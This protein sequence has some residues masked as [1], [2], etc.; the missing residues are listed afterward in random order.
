MNEEINA[1]ECELIGAIIGDGHI[2]K[3]GPKYYVG[4]TG[5]I[6]TDKK[7]FGYLSNLI[8]KT[9]NKSPQIRKRAGGLRLRF[10]S[11]EVV[12]RLIKKFSLPFNLGKCYKVKIPDVIASD[13]GLLRH[14]IRGIADTDGSVFTANKPGSPNYPSIEITTT[15][16]F[17]ASQLRNIL[18]K[19]GFKVA[20]IW[21]YKSKVSRYP[22]YKI[23]LNGRKNL[24]KWLKEIGFSNP[25][26]LNKA[27]NAL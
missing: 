19:Q 17:L 5:N 12:E 6:Q 25:Y 11:K 22:A 16:R 26:K 20:K 7:Y 23:P 3:K 2:H 8:K 4:V 15:S 21:G 9:W 27:L 10:Y 14:T 1:S 18:N 24:E 13:W